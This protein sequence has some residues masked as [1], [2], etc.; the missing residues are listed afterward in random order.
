MTALGLESKLSQYRYDKK[1]KHGFD[2]L[3]KAQQICFVAHYEESSL[4]I[5]YLQKYSFEFYL[6]KRR[7]ELPKEIQN[8][9]LMLN[10]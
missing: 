7:S 8:R 6:C 2:S 5:N 1:Y 10:L 9:L 4:F 3:L